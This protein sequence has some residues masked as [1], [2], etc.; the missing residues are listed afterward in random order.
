MF[1]FIELLFESL[2]VTPVFNLCLRKNLT[3]VGFFLIN[4]P[5][6]VCS[7]NI[8]AAHGSIP[9]DTSKIQES[10]FVPMSKKKIRQS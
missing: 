1:K 10:G 6:A 7:V 4:V 8:F 2:Y 3:N 5:F 9:G